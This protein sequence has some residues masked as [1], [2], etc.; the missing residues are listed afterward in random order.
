MEQI[1]LREI[2]EISLEV[3]TQSATK[4]VLVNKINYWQ[5]ELNIIE[6]DLDKYHTFP[7]PQAQ[8]SNDSNKTIF[9][10]NLRVSDALAAVFQAITHVSFRFEAFSSK[11][12]EFELVDQLTSSDWLNKS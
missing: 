6:G 8:T 2:S 9:K 10:A 1:N 12:D 4:N 3:L 7:M 5:V 11:E